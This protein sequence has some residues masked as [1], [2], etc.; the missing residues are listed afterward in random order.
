MCFLEIDW[1]IGSPGIDFFRGEEKT[2]RMIVG[3]RREESE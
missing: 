3:G 2:D 1:E